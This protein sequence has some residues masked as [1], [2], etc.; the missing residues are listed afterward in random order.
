MNLG[1][2]LVGMSG[3]GKTT[4]G[5]ILADMCDARFVDTDKLIERESGSKLQDLVTKDERAFLKTEERVLLSVN[6]S[7]NP[8]VATGGSAVYSPKAM[9]YFR[10]NA[11]VIFLEV[12]LPVLI[13]R[14][15]PEGRGIVGLGKKTY[16]ELARER[17]VLYR[18]SSDF[19][20]KVQGGTPEETARTIT[21]LLKN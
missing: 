10:G 9:R 6:L 4:V 7:D 16:A 12:P 2:V 20:L 1:I 11:Y 15:E 17:E 5:Q 14:V 18:I 13:K 3:A 21:R 19:T 8:V